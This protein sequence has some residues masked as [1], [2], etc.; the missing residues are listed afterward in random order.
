MKPAE[1]YEL[2]GSRTVLWEHRGEIPLRDTIKLSKNSL[3]F[4]H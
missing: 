3:L 2:K 4:V 1:P